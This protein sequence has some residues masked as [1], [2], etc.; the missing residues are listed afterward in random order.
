MIDACLQLS[1]DN[2]EGTR[3]DF[4]MEQWNIIDTTA[5][6]TDLYQKLKLIVLYQ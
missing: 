5:A 3:I 4:I 6:M 1:S 2:T